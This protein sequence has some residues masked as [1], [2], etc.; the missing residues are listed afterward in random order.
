MKPSFFSFTLLV[1]LY[2]LPS[3]VFAQ[4]AK[5][6]LMDV[7]Q[8]EYISDPQVSPMGSQIVF[9]RNFKDVMTDRN[10]SNLWISDFQGNQMRPLTTGMQSDGSPRWSPDGSR[11]LYRSSKNGSSQLFMRWLDSGAEAQ[12]SNLQKSPGNIQWSPDGKWISFTMIVDAP[13]KS[14]VQLPKP[15]KGA[16]WT[17]PPKYIEELKFKADGAGFLK[18][19]Y[20][21][22]FVMSADGGYARQITSGDYNHSDYSWAPDSKSIVF[23]AR[24]TKNWEYE[25]KNSDI[26]EIKLDSSELIQLTERNGPDNNPIISPDGQTIA[27]LSYEDKYLGYQNSQIHLMNRNGSGQRLVPLKLDRNISN[28]QWSNDGQFLYFQYD[29]FGNTYIAR[30]DMNGA[31]EVL[32]NN[33]G[34]LSLGRPYAGG[35]FHVDGPGDHVAFTYG[36]PEHPADLGITNLNLDTALRLTKV[37]EDLFGY[38]KLGKVEEL[39]VS[40]S[41]DQRDIQAWVCY[42]PDF[43]PNKKYPLILEI[44]GGPFANYGRRF[45]AEVQLYAAAGYVVV[46]ANP[47]G[48]TSYGEEFANLIHHNYPNQDYDD[49]MSV[50]DGVIEKGFI[51]TK[52][53][54]VTGGSGGGVLTAWIVGKTDRFRAAVVA[55]P[56]INWY[57]FVLHADNPA[58]FYRYWFPGYPWEH[59]EHY[60]KRSPISLVGN[61]TTPTMLLTGEQDYRTPMSETEQYYAALKLQKVE[62]ALVRIQDS[63]HGIASKPSNLINKVAYILGWF[64]KY[65]Q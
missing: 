8:M 12:I 5:L 4:D 31:Y 33:V 17:T 53:L 40:S 9:V 65:K 45:S 23:S 48:S 30:T 22:I 20:R 47:R 3:G 19:G 56:V 25:A 26:F 21:H 54:F 57:S 42:P 29:S 46:Y 41:Y 58:F 63:G 49:L 1:F 15:P 55:K 37:N 32:T 51:D 35:T 64:E 50:V 6:E 7:F 2:L 60:M 62:S 13:Q 18:P 43:D 16:N 59:Q 39:M 38:K 27:Y 34:G 36:T 28:I 52:N 10:R 14:L 24:R 11:I 44:H 61:V